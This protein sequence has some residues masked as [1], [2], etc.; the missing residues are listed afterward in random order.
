[1]KI[2]INLVLVA[3]AVFLGWQ[4]YSSI[5]DPITFMDELSV[6]EDAV[7]SRLKQVRD[8]Q[9]IYRDVSGGE[10]AKT[11]DELVNTLRNG[12]IPLVSV[13]G[14]PDDPNFDPNDLRTDTTYIP[15]IDTVNALGI[16]L[17][18]L[19]YIPY[20]GGRKEFGLY[21]DTTTYQK[22]LVNVV[23]VTAPYADFMGPFA[24]ER[25]K[26]YINTYDP[27]ATMKFG[28]R[29]KPTLSGSWD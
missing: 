2:V 17:D 8:A 9:T 15:A 13:F 24:D 23:E 4:L 10:Y 19:R 22:A 21:A 7:A 1:M 20:T 11:W 25:Y 12:N 28:S 27:G 18:S 16:D 6:R 3:I 29:A 5:K 26:R 14:D